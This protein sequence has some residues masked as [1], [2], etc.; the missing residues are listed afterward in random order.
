MNITQL[1]NIN[2]TDYADKSKTVLL[3]AVREAS[4]ILN[5][6]INTLARYGA[7]SG[8]IASD[9]YDYAMST[10]GLFNTVRETPIIRDG[11]EDWN[12]TRNELLKELS[13]A[14]RFAKMK[15]STLQGA[16]A[17]QK[18]RA[19]I[20]KNQYD[21]DFISDLTQE[22]INQLIA[23]AWEDFH[24]F[25][26]KHLNYSSSQLL[27][28]YTTENKDPANVEALLAKYAEEQ[29]AEMEQ[30]YEEAIKRTDFRPKWEF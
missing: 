19:E 15:T 18:Q 16:R 3:K 13:R 21:E 8:K 30:S 28:V 22:E 6:K 11:V 5:P 26:E 12:K 7:D 25:R 14:V 24:R 29:R 4:K 27:E 23:D 17:V 9:A 2:I 1:R 20:L 10:G